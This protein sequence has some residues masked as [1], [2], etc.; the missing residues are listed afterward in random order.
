V[1]NTAEVFRSKTGA[2]MTHVPFRGGPDATTALISGEIDV[3]LAIMS[4][5][6]GQLSGIS[7]KE[8]QSNRGSL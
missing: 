8:L 3:V 7:G 5:V 4:D 1:Y 6:T 2:D